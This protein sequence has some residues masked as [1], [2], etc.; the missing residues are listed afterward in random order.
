M[1]LLCDEMLGALARWLRAAGHDTALAAPGQPDAQVLAACEAQ[2]RTLITRDRRLAETARVRTPTVLLTAEGLE[3]DALALAGALGL[4]W[5]E[6]PFIRCMVDNALLAP[7]EPADVE[8]MPEESR[9][10]PGPFR[11]C[12][13]CGRLY[14]PGSHAR[15]IGQRLESWRALT[16]PRPSS[17]YTAAP[18]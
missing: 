1:R 11:K 4:D 5:T 18:G 6:A 2:G 3:Q 16:R 8:R 10:L 14:W 7:A 15:R 9:A 12:P 13:A 17:D